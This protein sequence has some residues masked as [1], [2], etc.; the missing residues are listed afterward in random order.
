MQ[1]DARLTK[2]KNKEKIA[3]EERK[4]RTSL[5]AAL[6]DKKLALGYKCAHEM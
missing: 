1:H 2:K 4:I 6:R 3:T 5:S